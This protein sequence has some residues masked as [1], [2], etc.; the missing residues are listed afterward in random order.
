MKLHTLPWCFCVYY[1]TKGGSACILHV[2]EVAN[3]IGILVVIQNL[4]QF[5]WSITLHK[6]LCA[7]QRN[8]LKQA[9]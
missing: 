1:G 7:W 3:S 4:E 5:I 2:T 8:V 6:I 9:G